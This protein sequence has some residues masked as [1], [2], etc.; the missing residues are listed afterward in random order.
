MGHLVFR[1][2]LL[3]GGGR[4]F[5]KERRNEGGRGWDEGEAGK[6][7]GSGGADIFIPHNWEVLSTQLEVNINLLIISQNPDFLSR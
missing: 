5:G 4:G 3:W 1:G 7:R 6:E 2:R